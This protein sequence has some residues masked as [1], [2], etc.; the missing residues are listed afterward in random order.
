MRNYLALLFFIKGGTKYL[1][2]AFSLGTSK[3]S[4][5]GTSKVSSLGGLAL[6]K[7]SLKEDIHKKEETQE[8]S[9]YVE[10]PYYMDGSK[11]DSAFNL[12]IANFGKQGT[13]LLE[14]VLV[15]KLGI[16]PKS[17]IP[18]AERPPNCL[19]FTLDND[20]VKQAE[21]L[22]ESRSGEVETNFASL[23]LYHVGC[24]C[25]D[26]LFDG[27]PIAR[28]WFLETIAR[29]PYFSYISVLHLYE[30]FGWWRGSALR[31]VHNAEED[32]ELHHLLIMEVRLLL[33]VYLFV[34]INARNVLI[35]ASVYRPLV[36]MLSGQTGS[37]DIT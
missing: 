8:T 28:F 33:F 31:K 7:S 24:F 34:R 20:A 26:E 18:P 12:A 30:S 32:N 27:R 16:I 15:E 25:L 21:E 6:A 5:L 23:A 36:E 29:I 2:K 35:C 1:V 9:F 13:A 3:V 14:Q 4:S 22:R 17:Y 11:P 19:G 10:N 37:L